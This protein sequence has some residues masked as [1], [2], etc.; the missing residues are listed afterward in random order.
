MFKLEL[1]HSLSKRDYRGGSVCCSFA[2]IQELILPVYGSLSFEISG[3]FSPRDKIFAQGGWMPLPLWQCPTKKKPQF[4]TCMKCQGSATQ[5]CHSTLTKP[6]G[7]PN[8]GPTQPAKWRDEFSLNSSTPVALMLEKRNGNAWQWWGKVVSIPPHSSMNLG[9]R[10]IIL[11]VQLSRAILFSCAKNDKSWADASACHNLHLP[12][13]LLLSL[14]WH[15]VTDSQ[16][17]IWG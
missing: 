8:Q 3:K 14:A 7:E 4:Q 10:K 9:Q 13:S 17:G 2:D 5:H 6:Q 15:L 12:L 11:K 16:V 1:I